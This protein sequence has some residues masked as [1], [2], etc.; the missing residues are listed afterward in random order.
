[1]NKLTKVA[2]MGLVA[3]SL[4][5]ASA[6][7]Q[8]VSTSA[9]DL[10]LGFQVTSGSGQGS[11]SDLEVDL[12][13]FSQF[14]TGATLTLNQ[15]SA[16]D[17]VTTYG[18]NWATRADLTWGVAG[19]SSTT[20]NSFYA[21]VSGSNPQNSSS[22]SG[23]T[24]DIAPLVGGLGGVTQTANSTKAGIVAASQGTSWTSEVGLANGQGD[25]QYF[26]P[27]GS[28]ETGY[29][30]QSG[31]AGSIDL[32]SF[33][34]VGGKATNKPATELGVFDLS[35]TGVLTYDGIDAQAVPEPS[36]YALG[37]CAVL[38]FLVLKRRHSVA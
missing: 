5:S 25:F 26:N 21:T 36:A 13:D 14:T 27:T 19:M 38:L 9:T 4:A 24:G 23:P 6:S 7:A 2:M 12:G 20:A 32:Y 8:N 35:S 31:P 22:L 34:E 3:A 37:I 11:A 28:T 1:M 29:I 15:L 10:V 33:S 18:S 30:E 16:A 17:L